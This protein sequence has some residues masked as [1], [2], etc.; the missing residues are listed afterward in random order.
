MVN[1]K[2]KFFISDYQPN[3]FSTTVNTTHNLSN[4]NNKTIK[5]SARKKQSSKDVM[6]VNK[7]KKL[8]MKSG[9]M[10]VSES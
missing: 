6:Q 1:Y 10:D 7:S 2:K 9:E 8:S 4:N 5:A 3:T